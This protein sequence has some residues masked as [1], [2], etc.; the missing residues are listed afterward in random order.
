MLPTESLV[1]AL[2]PLLRK[3]A[4]PAR[5]TGQEWN[6]VH[7]DWDATAVRFLLAYPDLYE[8]GMSNLGLA[9]LYDILNAQPDVLAERVFAPWPDMAQQM[10]AQG[11]PLFSLE[12]RRPAAG[13]DVLGFSLGYE[14][15]Y[16]NVLETLDLAG[17]PLH[18]EERGDEHPLVIA[19]GSCAHNAEPLARYLDFL[20]LGEGEEVALEL[21]ELVREWKR[22][23]GRGRPPREQL[24]RR[25]AKI[26]GVYVPSLYDVTY[27][28]DGTVRAISPLAPEARARI[29]RR[30]V[31]TLP[32][33]PVRPVVP[34]LQTVHDRASLE[35]QRGCTQGCR[36]C[37]AGVIYRPVRERPLLEALLAV[38][39]LLANTGY[40]E[41]SLV[42]LSTTDYSAIE[43]L[44]A[45]LSRR[46]RQCPLAI[47]LPSLRVDAFSV[48][49]AET[50]SGHKK[51][52]L[53]FAPEAGTQRLRDA[54][55][56]KTTHQDLLQT[57]DLAF[58]RGWHTLKLYFMLGLPTE[59]M[60]DV[61]GIAS[62]VNEVLALGRRHA[63]GRAHVRVALSTF[64]P[65]PHT[66][67]QWAA[68]DNME[69]LEAKQALLR[70]RL[71][72]GPVHLS[73]QDPHVSALE[74]AL[75]RGDR[76]LAPVVERAWR[77]GSTFDAWTERFQYERWR[78]AF[79]AEGLDPAF[80]AARE[81]PVYE[82]LPWAHLDCGVS[83]AFLREEYRRVLDAAT[84][85]DCRG[86]D[87]VRCGM[88]RFNPACRRRAR[89][90]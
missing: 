50:L 43:E 90:R 59:T 57:A 3:V 65:K 78:A 80:Y 82:T 5:Y 24:L 74:A 49:L 12:S 51:G 29:T 18:A 15:T 76:R 70:S 16:T 13:F 72:K 52:S 26:D 9:I 14:L 54:L 36:F 44:V 53:T 73:W 69:A 85:P 61:E 66:P 79:E 27:N 4:R 87:C 41:L 55:N 83:P 35:I 81:R 40:E 89:G 34:Y 63:A 84:T 8:I 47:S 6:A 11:V 31:A 37:Q 67:L 71:R 32:P 64:I 56:K 19:G 60:E 23:R 77:G 39:A 45:A 28:A 88:Q 21:A 42:S 75:S 46:Y 7:K 20:V 58:S 86:R 68:Q 10:R 62:M 2:D 30:V 22:Q 48:R 25:A 33:A 17:I 38:D 1:L